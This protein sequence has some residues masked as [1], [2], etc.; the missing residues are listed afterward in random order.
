MFCILVRLLRT[1]LMLPLIMEI[2]TCYHYKAVSS[3]EKRI[4]VR[5]FA[6]DKV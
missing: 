6:K 3:Q 2:T 5:Y 1:F 4:F